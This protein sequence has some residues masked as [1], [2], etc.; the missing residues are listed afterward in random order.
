MTPASGR[1]MAL[2][3]PRVALISA[4]AEPIFSLGS[5][6]R[7]MLMPTGISGGR[8]ALQRPPDDQPQ[9]ATRRGRPAPSRPP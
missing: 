2:P 6:S 5:S 1:P 3:M 9:E 8:E 4:T 7:M